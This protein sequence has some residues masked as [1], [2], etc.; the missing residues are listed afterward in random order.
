M[1]M[2]R[3]YGR[4]VLTILLGVYLA[5]VMVSTVYLG[6]HFV[7]DVIAGLVLGALAVAIGHVTIYGLHRRTPGRRPL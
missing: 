3:Y 1:L 6:W 4:R 2:A 5:A 7:V